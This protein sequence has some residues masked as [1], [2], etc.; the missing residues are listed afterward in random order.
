MNKKKDEMTLPYS[1]SLIYMDRVTGEISDLEFILPMDS[2]ITYI[3][4]YQVSKATPD[5]ADFISL[6]LKQEDFYSDVITNSIQIAMDP[7]KYGITMEEPMPVE[8]VNS[9]ITKWGIKDTDFWGTLFL[10]NA[11]ALVE[12]IQKNES[13]ED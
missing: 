9:L 11:V 6:A 1:A 4:L 13:K 5:D 2:M 3:V 7:E 10:I 8:L 12:Q